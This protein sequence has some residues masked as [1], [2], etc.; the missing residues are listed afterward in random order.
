MVQS[1]LQSVP[2]SKRI[3]TTSGASSRAT[4]HHTSSDWDCFTT[5]LGTFIIPPPLSRNRKLRHPRMMPH[6]ARQASRLSRLRSE[7]ATEPPRLQLKTV[8]QRK[9]QLTHA[10]A[11][12]GDYPEA[13]SGRDV[14]VGVVPVRMV[15]EVERFEPEL[16]LVPL[17]ELEVLVHREIE[18]DDTG[19]FESTP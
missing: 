7:I 12:A 9:L 5:P 2:T 3:H 4:A 13:R 15:R 18:A 14:G 19:R 1:P 8:L 10:E 16:Q 6:L 17:G 11:R